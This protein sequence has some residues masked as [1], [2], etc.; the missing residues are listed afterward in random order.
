MAVTSIYFRPLCVPS[1]EL[2]S[3]GSQMALSFITIYNAEELLK[4]KVNPFDNLTDKA[5][6][7]KLNI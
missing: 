6:F 2:K 5:K 1:I 7:E 3:H 4:I